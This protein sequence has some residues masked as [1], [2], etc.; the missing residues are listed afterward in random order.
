MCGSVSVVS[1]KFIFS[2]IRHGI[3]TYIVIIIVKLGELRLLGRSG[4]EDSKK[5]LSAQHEE[6]AQNLARNMTSKASN[7]AIRPSLY[8][9]G[10]VPKHIILVKLL[11]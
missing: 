4:A 8:A 9:L 1:L 2:P 3:D 11:D 10:V 5:F 6:L 7:R